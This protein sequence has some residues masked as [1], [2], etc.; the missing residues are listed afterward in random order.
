MT[1]Y[2]IRED[3]VRTESLT[4]EQIYELVAGTSGEIPSGLDEAFITKLK[5][6][7]KGNASSIWIGTSAEYNAIEE[8]NDNVLYV[9]LDD[10]FY[11]DLEAWQANIV[12]RIEAIEKKLADL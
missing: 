10:T 5:E 7:N 11:S 4:K 2:V 9:L 8:K 6:L 12:E 1:Y 3:G